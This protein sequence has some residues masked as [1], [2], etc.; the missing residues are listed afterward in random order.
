MSEREPG[1]LLSRLISVQSLGAV[2]EAAPGRRASTDATRTSPATALFGRGSVNVD[3]NAEAETTSAI[4]GGSPRAGLDPAMVTPSA[5]PSATNRAWWRKRATSDAC[6]GRACDLFRN[7]SSLLTSSPFLGKLSGAAF[8]PQ[9]VEG[10][11][12]DGAGPAPHRQ[13]GF[14]LSGFR[15]GSF[16]AFGDNLHPGAVRMLKNECKERLS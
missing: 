13:L 2:I 3:P 12:L 6:R 10:D 15:G 5:T 16:T 9:G 14:W 8:T 7:T 1:G 11:E 4:E